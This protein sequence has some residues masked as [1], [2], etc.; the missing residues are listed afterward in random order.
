MTRLTRSFFRALVLL[1][2]C[3]VAMPRLL[4]AQSSTASAQ[5]PRIVSFDAP[6]ADLNPG[7]NNGTYPGGI[8]VWGAI[9]GPTKTRTVSFHGFLRSHD[10]KFTTFDVPDADTSPYNGTNPITYQRLGG[11]HGNLL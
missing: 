4:Q 3:T 7:D 10:G 9:T 1:A 5:K 6:G 11:D 2:M 8:N